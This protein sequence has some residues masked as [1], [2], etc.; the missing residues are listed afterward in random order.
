MTVTDA[1]AA[2]MWR[3]FSSAPNA[4]P[5]N[6]IQPAVV[7]FGDPGFPVNGASAPLAAAAATWN[8]KDADAAPEI[9]LNEA[10]WKS[11]KGR[12]SRMPKPRHRLIIGS[13]RDD[14]VPSQGSASPDTDG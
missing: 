7:P 6:A 1:R 14:V 10:I 13:Q 9:A 2:R 11:I 4:T 3:S 5:Y 8:L 12:H